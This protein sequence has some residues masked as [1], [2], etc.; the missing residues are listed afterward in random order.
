MWLDLQNDAGHDSA[1]ATGGDELERCG[2]RTTRSGSDAPLP[3][4]YDTRRPDCPALPLPR[5]NRSSAMGNP[6]ARIVEK[7]DIQGK[8]SR[9][10]TT[11]TRHVMAATCAHVDAV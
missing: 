6:T 10:S 7:T 8:V 9:T 3:D 1:T 11:A 5:R 2:T 4:A